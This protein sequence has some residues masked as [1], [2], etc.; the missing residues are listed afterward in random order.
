MGATLSAMRDSEL[1]EA[2]H[3]EEAQTFS[4]WDFSPLDGRVSE[5]KPPWSYQ[6]TARRVLHGALTAVDLGTGGGEV[7]ATLRDAYAPRMFATEAYPPN[8]EL[9][10]A[11]LAPLGVTVIAY[12]ANEYVAPLPFDDEYFDV[13][14]D[15]HE[16]YD[17]REVARVLRAGGVFLTQQVDSRSLDDLRAFLGTS[18]PGPEVTLAAHTRSLREAGLAVEDAHEWSGRIVFQDVG[19]L[20]YYL[21]AVPWVVPHFTVDAYERELFAL[22]ARLVRGEG[23][24]FSIGRFLIRARRPARDEELR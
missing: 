2:W 23:L 22:H 1:L 5:E 12:E 20:V 10:R 9:A 18:W 14:L 24:A 7:L 21:K 16:A 8:L 19:A 11:R 15:R 13:V 3:R 4:G 17:S 6:D